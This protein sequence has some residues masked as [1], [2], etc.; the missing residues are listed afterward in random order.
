MQFIFPEKPVTKTE[1]LD[2]INQES[3]FCY[4]LNIPKITKKLIVNP[5]R[6]DHKPTASFYKSS[7]GNV[8]MKD[9][10]NGKTYSCF[11]VVMEK[12]N[13]DFFTCLNIIAKDFGIRNGSIS[14]KAQEILNTPE[15]KEKKRTEIKV[16]IQDFTKDDLNY[17]N[18][19]GISKKTL[20]YYNI[21]SC[22]AV[23][24]NNI[25]YSINDNKLIYGYF[26]GID[27]NLEMWRVYYPQ[28]KGTNALRF[29]GNWPANKI[30]GW[31]QLPKSGKLVIITKSLKDVALLH[32][33]KLPACAPCSEN[34]G[35]SDELLDNLKKRFKYIIVLGDNDKPG[36]DAMYRMKKEHPELIYTWF[37]KKL[38]KDASDVYKDC[39]KE[40]FVKQITLFLNWLKQQP[41][42]W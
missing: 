42:K 9:F 21:Y 5:L 10:G 37:P 11:A 35:I 14:V 36:I 15:L 41:A 1:I 25:I 7:N 39:G 12:Y 2:K 22:K 40:T 6:N 31:E 13:C 19:F 34:I 23:W 17:W 38:G 28:N 32:E 24:L 29:L 18:S 33:Y 16:Q 8:Y 30:Q 27:D 3:L 4:Y 20:E 26:G